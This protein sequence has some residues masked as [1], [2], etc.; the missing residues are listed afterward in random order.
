L[1]K[2]DRG[3][4]CKGWTQYERMDQ[5]KEYLN[6]VNTIYKAIVDK[7]DVGVHAIDR[8]GKTVIYNKK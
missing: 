8:T 6:Y 1:F 5:R 2:L 3:A 4:S 7:I